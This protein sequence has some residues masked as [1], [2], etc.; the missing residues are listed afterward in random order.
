MNCVLS[1]VSVLHNC[2]H[3]LKCRLFQ[4][5]W[6]LPVDVPDVYCVYLDFV[7]CGVLPK[8]LPPCTLHFLAFPSSH[9]AMMKVKDTTLR[10][11]LGR[12][13][14]MPGAEES[15]SFLRLI[16]RKCSMRLTTFLVGTMCVDVCVHLHTLSV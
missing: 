10:K 16:S 12:L 14:S 2:I 13:C 15:G 3:R 6:L 11:M 5:L 8:G 7:L 4:I 9:P 1:F